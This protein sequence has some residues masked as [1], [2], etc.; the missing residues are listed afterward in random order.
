MFPT[1]KRINEFVVTRS[2]QHSS[3]LH[4][5]HIERSC[6]LTH[7]PTFV[8][9]APPPVLR[10]NHYGVLNIAKAQA[11]AAWRENGSSPTF[12]ASFTT[13]FIRLAH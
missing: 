1:L 5:D 8:G 7:F 9:R 12:R 2:F 11:Q 10:I 6:R 4:T 3:V 13:S